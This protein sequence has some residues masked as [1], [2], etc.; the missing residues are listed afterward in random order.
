MD[1]RKGIEDITLPAGWSKWDTL[2]AVCEQEEWLL[3]KEKRIKEE[4]SNEGNDNNL[5]EINY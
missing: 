1:C 5:I 3:E 2:V 4:T